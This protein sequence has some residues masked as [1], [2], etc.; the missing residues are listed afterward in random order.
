MVVFNCEQRL[1]MNFAIKNMVPETIRIIVVSQWLCGLGRD[2]IAEINEIGK[3]TVSN[4]VD[5]V[6]QTDPAFDLMRILALW[7]R[8][9]GLTV[10]D[11]SNGIRLQNRLISLDIPMNSAE[12]LI[13]KLH[14]HCFKKNKSVL[15]FLNEM[16]DQINMVEK[17]GIGLDEFGPLYKQRLAEKAYYEHLAREAKR[18][19][20]FELNLYNTT[21]EE[22]QRFSQLEYVH[23]RL[24]EVENESA[25]KDKI[26]NEQ[27]KEIEKMQKM[28]DKF[29][30][31]TSSRSD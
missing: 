13:T 29:A 1:Y 2:E 18:N 28:L 14:E 27:R 22:L 25:R 7:L 11:F 23:R 19:R 10:Q 26:I 12:L 5:E 24:F 17:A 30:D 9:E 20:E 16:L 3:G 31:E 6:R 21:H 8:K 4:I 15:G